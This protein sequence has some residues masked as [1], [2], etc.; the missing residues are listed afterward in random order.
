MCQT[1]TKSILLRDAIRQ[2]GEVGV[3]CYTK[4]SEVVF[5]YRGLRVRANGQRK[6]VTRKVVTM[7][8]AA[9]RAQEDAR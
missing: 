8:R 9:Q 3:E 6:D 7:L 4:G 5:S 2:A 1:I